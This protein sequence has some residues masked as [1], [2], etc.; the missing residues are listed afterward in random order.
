MAAFVLQN[1]YFEFNGENKPK[2]SSI[3]IDAK[4][5][6]LHIHIYSWIKLN[7]NF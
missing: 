5:T 3:A 7:Q 1:N 2:I 6:Y 4:F